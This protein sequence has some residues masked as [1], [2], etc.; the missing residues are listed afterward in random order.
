MKENVLFFFMMNF[1]FIIVWLLMLV[2]PVSWLGKSW[3]GLQLRLSLLHATG[4]FA[5]MAWLPSL[6]LS[7]VFIWNNLSNIAK[8]WVICVRGTPHRPQT[9]LVVLMSYKEVQLYHKKMGAL[10]VFLD[11]ST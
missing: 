7:Q 3:D 8:V 11:I 2:L 4:D 6:L 5:A 1:I 10:S 9:P